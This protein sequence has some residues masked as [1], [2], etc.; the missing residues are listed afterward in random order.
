[1]V[2]KGPEALSRRDG[3]TKQKWTKYESV[4]KSSV[5]AALFGIIRI[6]IIDMGDGAKGA[7]GNLTLVC[8]S[9]FRLV[10]G[11]R[12]SRGRVSF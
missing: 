11:E 2:A 4:Q 5:Y 1:M 10:I 6:Y 8:G 3:R 9:W 7:F 12:K